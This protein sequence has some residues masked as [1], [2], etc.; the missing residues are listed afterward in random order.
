[1][2]LA[3]ASPFKL[4]NKPREGTSHHSFHVLAQS[5]GGKTSRG[6]DAAGI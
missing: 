6:Y 3:W 2:I 5:L 4:T 1:M